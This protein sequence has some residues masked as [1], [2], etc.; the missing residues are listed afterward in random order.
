[1][2][3]DSVSVRVVEGVVVSNKMD[4][5]VVVECKR[6]IKNALGKFVTKTTKLHAHDEENKCNNGDTIHVVQ[7]RPMSKTKTWKVHSIVEAK[8]N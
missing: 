1:M 7:S 5:T 3:N 2:A 6:R 4:K 8:T